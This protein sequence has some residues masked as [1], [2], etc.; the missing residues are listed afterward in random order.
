MVSISWMY[1]LISLRHRER[2]RGLRSRVWCAKPRLVG[3]IVRVLH[4]YAVR[5]RRFANGQQEQRIHVL[6]MV[7]VHV[8]LLHGTQT[9]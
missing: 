5:L 1:D 2:E 9:S 8:V 7:G 4:R 3:T 6:G